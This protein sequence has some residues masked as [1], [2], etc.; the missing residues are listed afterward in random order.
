MI[1][2]FISE[3]ESL[4]DDIDYPVIKIKIN[5]VQFVAIS[6]GFEMKHSQELAIC[7][8]CIWEGKDKDGA[9]IEYLARTILLD[10]TLFN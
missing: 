4:C 8:V 5:N 10:R 6:T 2:N 3:Y 9:H 7:S 1:A